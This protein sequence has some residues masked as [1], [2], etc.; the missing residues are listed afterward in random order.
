MSDISTAGR[1]GS[2]KWIMW[3]DRGQMETSEAVKRRV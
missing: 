1:V 2:I 3:T